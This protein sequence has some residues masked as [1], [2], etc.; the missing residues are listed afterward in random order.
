MYFY[1]YTFDEELNQNLMRCYFERKVKNYKSQDRDAGREI[2]KENYVDTK[3]LMLAV[4]KRCCSCECDVFISFDTGNTFS[5]IT[6]DRVN[7]KEDHNIFNIRPMCRW[8]N[9]CQSDNASTA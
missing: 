5:N 6:A 3:W 8:C 1:D 4:N 7:C 2:S 9:T